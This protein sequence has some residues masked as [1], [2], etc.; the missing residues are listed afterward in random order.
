M[1]DT[2][3]LNSQESRMLLAEQIHD[4]IEFDGNINDPWDLEPL[5][6]AN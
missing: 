2:F 1:A 3:L 5:E 4:A 6:E